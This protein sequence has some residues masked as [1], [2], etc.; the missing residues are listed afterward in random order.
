M[1]IDTWASAFEGANATALRAARPAMAGKTSLRIPFSVQDG[2]AIAAANNTNYS[3]FD[4]PHVN[5]AIAAA[6]VRTGVARA[7]AWGAV[8]RLL[9]HD[10]AAIPLQWDTATLIHSKDV[11]GVA[12]H[13]SDTWDLSY[14]GLK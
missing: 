11:A 1:P 3:Q 14:T 5:A 10:A 8:D 4:D 6:A 12:S 7:R 9:V 2:H 13:Y